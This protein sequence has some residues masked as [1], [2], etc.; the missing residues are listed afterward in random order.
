MQ[1]PNTFQVFVLGL[2]FTAAYSFIAGGR[3]ACKESC[4]NRLLRRTKLGADTDDAAELPDLSSLAGGVPDLSKI[5]GFDGK[6]VSI[7]K[8]TE[9]E[10]SIRNSFFLFDPFEFPDIPNSEAFKSGS[11]REYMWLQNENT[12]AVYVPLDDPMEESDIAEGDVSVSFTNEGMEFSLG[13]AE[14]LLTGEFFGSIDATASTWSVVTDQ[15]PRYV[16]L[17]LNKASKG[18]DWTSIFKK[19]T[20]Q[21]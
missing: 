18:D 9:E 6:P 17:Q 12:V 2:C 14:T 21:Q 15:H 16:N 7:P 8:L 4:N 11:Q 1:K 10:A 3:L 13:G 5:M 20:H 19:N